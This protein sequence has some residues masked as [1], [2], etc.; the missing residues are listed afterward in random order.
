ME[1]NFCQRASWIPRN[2][3]GMWAESGPD[4]TVADSG[5]KGGSF[6]LVCGARLPLDGAALRVTQTLDRFRQG[7]RR[8]TWWVSP[9]SEP[10]N[11]PILL[12]QCGLE[13]VETA[14]TMAMDLRLLERKA[15]APV[16]IG[17]ARVTR[18]EALESYS[19]VI[20]SAWDPSDGEVFE[21][22]RRAAPLLLTPDSPSLLFLATR[23]GEAV[24]ACE[25]FVGAGIAGVYGLVTRRAARRQG[26]ATA[27]LSFALRTVR[28]L[29]FLQAGLQST[30]EASGM[31]Y[32]LGFRTVGEFWLFEPQK[33]SR[34]AGA[35]AECVND[36][37][38]V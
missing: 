13:H 34:T 38:S 5:L 25:I 29:G 21:Y 4:L 9:L 12:E 18:K 7:G 32:Q 30:R 20:A 24:G 14:T 17:I 22:Y 23:M 11:L 27:L 36:G 31:Y 10:E 2:T 6:N 19:D 37:E 33:D 8:L 1:A 3:S 28:D 26:I 15:E 35:L 16:N